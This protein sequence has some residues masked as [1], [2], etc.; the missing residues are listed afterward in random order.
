MDWV[1][2]EADKLFA[3]VIGFYPHFNKFVWA[4]AIVYT[5]S[6]HIQVISVCLYP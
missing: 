2:L 5:D 6:G 3:I 1:S 4:E